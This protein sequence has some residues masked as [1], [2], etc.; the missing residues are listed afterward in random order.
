MS[1]S[2]NESASDVAFLSRRAWSNDRQV[3]W[4]GGVA[5]AIA[6]AVVAWWLLQRQ[7][8]QASTQPEA[9]APP[10][11]FRSTPEQLKTLSIT[12][13]SSA[14]FRGIEVTDGSIAFNGD[15][16]TPVF[17]PYSGHI[18]HILAK[19]G[20][21]LRRG[22]PLATIDASE[23]VQAQSDLVA[24]VAQSKLA[25]ANESRKRGLYEAKG[26]SLQDW[27]QAQADLAT[28]EGGLKAVR[29]RLRILGKTDAEIDA[30]ESSDHVNATATLTAPIDGVVVD[31]QLGPGQY[32]QAGSGA[33]VFT[34]ADLSSVWLVANVREEDAPLVHTGQ[35]VE[36][37]VDAFPDQ[38]FK[39]HVV[40]VAAQ[41]DA[42]THRL[43]VR[44]EM[45]NPSGALK[46]AMFAS[47]RIITSDAVASP[48]VPEGAVVYDGSQAHVWVLT[49]DA[50][51]PLISLRP[52]TVG[53]TDQRVVQVLTGLKVGER[54]VTR[55]S[56]FIDRAVTGD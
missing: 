16:T 26:G 37:S 34:L 8:S 5:A 44:A 31:R 49:S 35:S 56:L 28:A 12:P 54:V 30:L 21:T 20:D 38:T 9:P 17:S 6:L 13:V 32:V 45:A 40:Y 53:R 2:E 36:V 18:I 29:N 23:F 41:V 43:Q 22:A 50:R 24:A 4:L 27:Q 19:P 3:R 15:R 46:P 48:A 7:F 1:G 51:G 52:I 47:F 39:A 55:G 42:N 33:A 14:A 25:R 11:T 10:G